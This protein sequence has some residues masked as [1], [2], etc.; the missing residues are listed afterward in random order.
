MLG[1]IAFTT[2]SVMAG[3]GLVVVDATGA[4]RTLPAL[5]SEHGSSARVGEVARVLDR[6]GDWTRVALAGDREGWIEHVV[7]M[8]LV[9]D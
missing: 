8:P 6:R 5:A 9:R 4:L 2:H 1:G 7:L 3:D